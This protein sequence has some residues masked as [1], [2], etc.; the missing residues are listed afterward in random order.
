MVAMVM[1]IEQIDILLTLKCPSEKSLSYRLCPRGGGVPTYPLKTIFPAE[2]MH[3]NCTIDRGH[4]TKLIC[5]EK[6]IKC[7]KMAA[8]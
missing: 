2:C 4:K 7:F 8:I 6:Q 5:E 3:T 1:N